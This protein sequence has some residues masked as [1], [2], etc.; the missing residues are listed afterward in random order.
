MPNEPVE[1]RVHG[2]VRNAFARPLVRTTVRAFD[3]DLRSEQLLGETATDAKGH[4]TITYLDSDFS[5]A[6]KTRADLLV[7]AY[8][9][10]NATVLVESEL[11]FNAG[12]DENVD[13][14]AGGEEYR[15]LS[16]YEAID[17]DLSPILLAEGVEPSQLT[18]DDEAFLAGDTGHEEAHIHAF[19]VADR[20]KTDAINRVREF[21]PA[22]PEFTLEAY[23]LY[24]LV[25][26]GLGEEL[27]LLLEYRTSKLKQV[28][29][30]AL[31]GNVIR[32]TKPNE[33][34]KIIERLQELCRNERERP[35][36]GGRRA[37]AGQVP[38]GPAR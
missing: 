11:I 15:G 4:Y 12:T 10:D 34:D 1:F 30:A 23:V 6:E 27:G 38:P 3:K 28:L 37:A 26:A 33:W 35:G 25:R 18:A 36:S 13:L 20:L 29:E 7:R 16:E 19:G 17:Q 5:Y 21:T 31:A 9:T 8:D 22:Y 24:A 14:M 32:L 2:S